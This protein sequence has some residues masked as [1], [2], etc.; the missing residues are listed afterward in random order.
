M[1]NSL[2]GYV[3]EKP[4][5]G[6]ANSPFT[7]SPDNVISDSGAYN[8]VFGVDESN[9]GRCEYLILALVDGDLPDVEFGWT[10]NEAGVQRFDYESSVG[11]FKPMPGAGRRFVGVLDANSNTTRLKVSVPTASV[12]VAPFRVSV[13]EIGSGTTFMAVLVPDDSSF[14]TPAPGNVQLSQDT[15]NLNWNTTDISS[16]YVGQSVYY[17]QQSFFSRQDST[18]RLGVAGDV[19]VLNPIPGTGQ[20]PLIRFG[21]G[22][23]LSSVQVA[24][25]ASF[26]VNP[27]QGTVEWALTTGRLKFNAS[28]LVQNVGEVVYYDGLLFEIGK[29]LPRQTIGTISSPTSIAGLPS[30]GGDLVF[31]A[32]K[33]SPLTGTATFPSTSILQD[34]SASFVTNKV[35]VGDVVI[36]TSGPN[37]GSRRAV[38]SVSPTQL[39]VAPPFPSVAGGTYTIE[40]K[41]DIAQFLNTVR[42]TALSS[43]GKTGTVQVDGSGGV[44]FSTSDQGTYGSRTAEVV[45]GDLPIERGLSV[46]YY[47]SQVDLE[48]KDPSIKD[49]STFFVVEDS[50]LADP[51]I[52]AP[53][54]FLPVLPIDDDAYPTVIAVEQGTGSFTGILPRLD[55]AS[56]PSGLGYTLDFE[57]K[58]LLYSIRRNAQVM[59]IQSRVAAFQLPD[60]LVNPANPSFELNQGVGFVPLVLGD[61]ALLD[62][63]SGIL[64]F[65]DTKGVVVVEG[66]TGV[67]QLIA[68]DTL[69]DP[70]ADFVAA[71]VDPQDLLVVPTGPLQ[72][73]YMV[74]SVSTTELE[75]TPSFASASTGVQYQV[76]RGKEILADRFFQE[77]LTV[78][79]DTKVEKVRSAGAI[80]NSPRVVVDLSTVGLTRVKLPSGAIVT[81]VQVANDGAF[82]APASLTS[83]SVEVSLS[84]GNLN[85]SQAD[86]TSG[87][88]V[89]TVLRLIQGVDYKMNPDLGFIQF[90]ERMLAFDEVLV[91][92]ASESDPTA[93]N[94]ERG[95]FLIR[96]EVLDHPLATSTM[97]FNPTGRTVA[98]APVPAVFRGGRPQS[99]SQVSVNTTGSEITF[100]PDVIPTPGGALVVTDATPHGPIVQPSERI[101]VDYYVHQAIGGENTIT[102]LNPPVSMTK[103]IISDGSDFFTIKGDWTSQFISDHLLRLGTDQVYYITSVVYDGTV[104][105]VTIGATFRE[106]LQD[107]KIYISSG[108]IRLVPTVSNPAY[109]ILESSAYAS[110]PRGMNKFKIQGDVANLYSGG[111]VLYFSG[112]ANEFYIVSGAA[113]D[114][115][116]DKTEVTLTQPAARQ[117]TYPTNAL[118]RSYLPIF[119]EA[120]TT[121]RTSEAP[122]VVPPAT[123]LDSVLVY[124]QIEGEPGVILSSPDDYKIDDSGKIDLVVPLALGEEVSALYTKFRFVNPGQLR[125]SYTAT[126][127]PTA[128][129]GLAGQILTASLTTFLPDS[130]YFRIE[131]MTT[132]QSE[133]SEEYKAE[134]KASAPSG[135]PRTDNTSQPKLNDQGKASVYFTEGDLRN[136]DIIARSALKYYNDS[137]NHLEDLLRNMDGR[138]VG[139]RDG[140]FIFDGTT[141]SVV[142]SFDLAMNQIDDRF[143]I[144][145]FPIDKTPPL[146]P[147]KYL[148]TYLKAYEASTSSR[149]YSTFRIK[150]GYTVAG[151]DTSAKTGDSIL[152]FEV[153]NL[154]ALS[155]TTARR[156]PRAM[157]TKTAKSG[158][159]TVFV[160]N[161]NQVDDVP[162]RP[163]FAN[164]MK[165]VIQDPN[166]TFYVTQGSPLTIASKTGTSITFTTGLPANIPIG[167]SVFLADSDTAYRKAYRNGFDVTADLDKGFL[168][169]VK[170]YPP[171]DGSSG[172]VPVELRIQTPNSNELL[173][174]GLSV[175]NRST[176]PERIPVLDGKPL[177]DDSDQRLPLINPS[178]AREIGNPG[179]L[180]TELAYIGPSGS[181][182]TNAVAPFMG[183]GNLN[184]SGTTI[185]LTSGTF[186]SPVPQAGDLVRILSGLNGTTSFR[187][188][189][190]ASASSVTVDVA[191]SSAPD[192]NFSFLVTVAGNLAVGTFQ[193]MVGPVVTDPL[194]NFVT[195]GVK[196]GHTVVLTQ[197][198]HLAQYQRRQVQSVS[199]TSLTLTAPFTSLIVPATYRVHNPLNTYSDIGDLT[200][201]TSVLS[202]I[203]V[204]NADSE[205][206]SIDQFLSLT[207]ADR[208]SP[209]LASGNTLG[210]VITGI[211]VNFVTSGVQPGDLVYL[212]P[213]QSSQGFYLVEEVTTTTLTVS[214]PFLTSGAVSFRVVDAEVGVT[215]LN[216]LLAA[217]TSATVFDASLP[218]WNAL[219]TTP[220]PVL[221]P[222]GVTDST[223]FARGYTPTDLS[224][225]TSAVNSRKAEVT[226]SVPKIEAVL[227]T[228]DRLYDKRYVW[229]DARINLEKGILVKQ[230]RAVADRIKAQEETLKQLTKLLAVG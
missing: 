70:S 29:T 159:L 172:S 55:T 87:G 53:A 181:L 97:S 94:T 207:L 167:A 111:V 80:T 28:D 124:R 54:V 44:R 23:Y 108:E 27:V 215:G 135:G 177:D 83:G 129:N 175:S 139:D 156:S 37:A 65:I 223:Y 164:A 229:I 161:A 35:K 34:G 4:R 126:V 227:A 149:F 137:I 132:F 33:T 79:P 174:A 21:F 85:F 78:D 46:R 146:F 158:D 179:Y 101:Y 154:T 169:Y 204:G 68:L 64:S 230:Q 201:T 128:D 130:T 66:S 145:D 138:V 211:G 116:T 219:V 206:N 71:G 51:I 32:K 162:Y 2:K 13:G 39:V 52:G 214:T 9:P 20:K 150:H 218:A 1:A 210:N 31:R 185:T 11:T 217:R 187:R 56:P 106:D 198:G 102:V 81:P 100:L 188:V 8:A 112:A 148:G 192:T 212:P 142:T 122:L 62:P 36:L 152:D 131:T 155:T 41:A 89:S 57:G 75:V 95:S 93:Y 49:L 7:A 133:V 6:A 84:T 24:N 216:D 61:D 228:S 225:R 63:T 196:P 30:E 195:A 115:E 45:F 86:V 224:N 140:K 183:T 209:T 144:S 48:G 14:T 104:T 208:L 90:A 166:G 58:Q 18:G 203:L 50:T 113:Y 143:K 43:P 193:T 136:E 42:V 180:E 5:V 202:G 184:G 77:I 160:D 74:V 134:A 19:L 105:T 22:L 72:G 109:F 168:L 173:E 91:T 205:V 82:T 117:Y 59:P 226:A 190:S 110:V 191:F 15:G 213:V 120:T 147:I 221:V 194:A 151:A 171:F 26:S 165:V 153:K 178:P 170:P 67:V 176:A 220:V 73:V 38:K 76:R 98:E 12:V 60:P 125:A 199:P 200:D 121:V 186:P 92:Y 96:K 103:V 69:E 40:K 141:G 118:R 123:L 127:V 107:P 189:S 197:I 88:T 16:T 25:E 163:A 222:P 99:S 10:K 47:R 157:V 182:S 114:A 119:E 17:Q 3:L